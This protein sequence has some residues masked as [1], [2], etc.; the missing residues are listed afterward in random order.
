[1]STCTILLI[2]G[3]LGLEQRDTKSGGSMGERVQPWQWAFILEIWM[4]ST[5]ELRKR[6]EGERKAPP[7]CL[8]D[9]LLQWRLDNLEHLIFEREKHG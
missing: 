9:E 5:N 2:L 1:M 6:L 4:T 3:K 8:S 7:I